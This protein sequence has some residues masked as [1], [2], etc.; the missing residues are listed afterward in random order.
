MGMHQIHLSG[1]E[2]TVRHDLEDIV[3]HCSKQG[4]YT[5]LITSGVL[6][7]PD[8]LKK[9]ESLG[10][11]HVQLSF[12]DTDHENADRIGGFKGG[13]AKKL[14]VAKWVRDVELP[15][16]CN[17]V[18]HRQNIDN[19]ENFIQMA[20]DLDAERVEIAQVQYYGWALKNRAFHP[21]T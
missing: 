20:L 19:L 11:E 2:P 18:V 1:G 21:Y 6:L 15:L 4:L 17:C 13:H 7:N 5:N 9:L 12:Q 8:R 10:L 16:T 3:E 14:E